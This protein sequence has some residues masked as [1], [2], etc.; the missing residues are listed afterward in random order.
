MSSTAF[1]FNIHNRNDEKNWK[2]TPFELTTKMEWNKNITSEFLTFP[3]S[4]NHKIHLC[5]LPRGCIYLSIKL[6]KLL[7]IP[8]TNVYTYFDTFAYY[9]FYVLFYMLIWPSNHVSTLLVNQ[10]CHRTILLLNAKC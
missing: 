9:L 1:Y 10:N 8:L 7:Y 6:S 3:T 2:F 5:S 4:T